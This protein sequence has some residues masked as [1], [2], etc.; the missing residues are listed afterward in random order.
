MQ[1]VTESVNLNERI[2]EF[3][4]KNR[5]IIFIS[6]GLIV[7]I[8]V[9][10][11][12]SIS[13]IEVFQKK[14][15]SEVEELNRRYEVLRF[16]IAEESVAGDV[17]TLLSD[18]NALAKKTSGYVGGK[19]WSIAASIHSDKKQWP[20]AESAW[21]DAAKTASKTYLAPLAY[22]NAAAA[23]EEQ[24]KTPE[25]IELYTQSANH[26]ASFPAAAHAQFSVGRLN[27]VLNNRDAALEAYR[28]LITK[29]PND[30]TWIN[31]AHSRIITLET[32]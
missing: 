32:K 21:L 9:G 11:V 19:A 8:L 2:N 18:L 25:A 30:T 3:V 6:L 1:N 10:T 24:G 15:I 27:E 5:K 4:Q 12:A 26:P 7:L 20:E 23:A 16:N 31:L 28:S 17:E 13:L 14:A 29:W 22:Y